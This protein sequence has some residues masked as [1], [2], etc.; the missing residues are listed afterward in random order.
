MAYSTSG[1]WSIHSAGQDPGLCY[2]YEPPEC[3]WLGWYRL[4]L[5]T[6]PVGFYYSWEPD[7]NQFLHISRI[8]WHYQSFHVCWQPY[9]RRVCAHLLI[10]CRISVNGLL[11]TLSSGTEGTNVSPKRRQSL[12]RLRVLSDHAPTSGLAGGDSA[13]DVGARQRLSTSEEW[14]E[15]RIKSGKNACNIINI[16]E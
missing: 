4:R 2:G 6:L 11:W 16:L 7:G 15:M 1:Q 10:R 9:P 5:N 12:A 14:V 3:M 8:F 13:V